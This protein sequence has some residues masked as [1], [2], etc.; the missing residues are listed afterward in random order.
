[1][2]KVPKVLFNYKRLQRTTILQVNLKCL[3]TL[4]S[5]I[6]GKRKNFDRALQL[7]EEAATEYTRFRYLFKNSF[8]CSCMGQT[9]TQVI[10]AYYLD[11]KKVL[12]ESLKKY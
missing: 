5:T 11:Q 7:Q 10:N 2:P 4:S 1:M 9:S 8:K 3:S 6:K 12:K